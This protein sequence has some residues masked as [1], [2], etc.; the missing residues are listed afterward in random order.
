MV[1]RP[2]RARAKVYIYT[3]KGSKD[4][5]PST[6]QTLCLLN[7]TEGI[8]YYTTYGQVRDGYSI[9]TMSFKGGLQDIMYYMVYYTPSVLLHYWSHYGTIMD[10]L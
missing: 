4:L 10:T 6:H 1:S 5:D 2:Y 8:L 7:S 9:S 3:P